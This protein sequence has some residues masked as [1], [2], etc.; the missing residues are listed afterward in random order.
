VQAPF[1]P[2]AIEDGDHSA[3][4][5]KKHLQWSTAESQAKDIQPAC[6]AL[7]G[8]GF[9]LFVTRTAISLLRTGHGMIY[10]NPF[11]AV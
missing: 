1:K 6:V 2:A 4:I 7:D 3:V 11:M 9:N 10:K 8:V 5:A